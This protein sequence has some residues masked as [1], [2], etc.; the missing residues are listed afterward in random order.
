MKKPQ[1]LF[2][3]LLAL[4]LISFPVQ[5]AQPAGTDHSAM[6]GMSHNNMAVAG[7]IAL[8]D[9][10]QD[11]IKASA[12]LLDV[13]QAKAKMGKPETHHFM[14]VFT[15]VKTGK[16]LA[17]TTVAVK[18]TDPADATGVASKMMAMDGSFGADVTLSQKGGYRFEVGTKFADGTKRQ[19]SFQY[20]RP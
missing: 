1:A 16:A 15:D 6:P 11:G 14:V 12:K 4:L 9:S 13:A 10:T 3:A 20:N 18:V 7:E 8:T 17:A 19:F 5:A 2:P